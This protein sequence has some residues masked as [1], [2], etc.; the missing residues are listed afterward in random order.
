MDGSLVLLGPLWSSRAER[1]D[2]DDDDNTD[3]REQD[4]RTS[5]GVARRDLWAATST[6]TA[7][8]TG[9]VVCMVGLQPCG[10]AMMMSAAAWHGCPATLGSSASS[11]CCLQCS[12]FHKIHFL[13]PSLCCLALYYHMDVCYYC[14][15]TK[16]ALSSI[17]EQLVLCGR[18]CDGLIMR[19]LHPFFILFY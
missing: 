5:G 12:L 9:K 6:A 1:G 4:V 19:F 15:L 10:A 8:A 16:V 14:L 2:D 3:E 17:I 7:T 13:G 11:S 18:A